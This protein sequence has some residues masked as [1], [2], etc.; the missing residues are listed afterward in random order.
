MKYP[1]ARLVLGLGTCA[2][3]G[4]AQT[5]SFTP[6]LTVPDGDSSGTYTQALIST[7]TTA[8]GSLSVSLDIS[9]ASG[10]INNGDLYVTLAHE[11]A[12]G[13]VDAFVVLL[14]RSGK[15]ASDATGYYDNGLSVTF[16]TAAVGYDIH[17][18]RRH[19]P[20]VNQGSDSTPLGG[21]LTGLWEP[22]G[23]NVSADSVTDL[24]PR[25][26]SLDDFAGLNPNGTWVLYLADPLKDTAGVAQL[27]SW[28]LHVTPVPEP[29]GVWAL[30]ALGLLGFGICRRL[31][32]CP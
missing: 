5:F 25:T 17:N 32:K 15:T 22:D 26:T 9:A 24:T 30:S 16:S 23:R 10:L 13:V 12:P 27:N 18:Y 31:Q 8:I 14:N 4:Q 20:G 11:S 21:P 28:S 3:A 29:A 1:L 2:V 6:G 19:V 7:A